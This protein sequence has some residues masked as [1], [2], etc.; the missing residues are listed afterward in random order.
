M[1]LLEV[2][3]LV[4]GYGQTTVLHEVSLSLEPGETLAVLGANGAGKSTLLRAISGL[5][6]AWRGAISFDGRDVTGLDAASR[7]AAGIGHVLEGR[8]LFGSMSVRDNLRV[9]EDIGS[10]GSRSGPTMAEV[11][12]L[13]PVLAERLEQRSETLSGGQ[14]Q[15]LAIARAL[16]AA[17][18]LLLLDEPSLGLSPV[19]RQHLA[20]HL[21]ELKRSHITILLVEQNLR[22]ARAICSQGSVMRRGRIVLERIELE[23]ASDRQLLDHY[24]GSGDAVDS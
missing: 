19:S 8:R 15:M 17:P 3:G 9:G 18:Q 16:L 10:R 22:F 12:S 23:Q 13:F 14:Q 24:I 5:E 2:R 6:P 1:T 21:G 20:A 4:S 7:A 11:L